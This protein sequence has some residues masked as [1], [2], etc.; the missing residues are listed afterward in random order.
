MARYSLLSLIGVFFII[1]ILLI[2]C[3]G[4]PDVVP[5][6]S[7][8]KHYSPNE[9]PLE[10][11]QITIPFPYTDKFSNG[12]ERWFLDRD[13]SN[14]LVLRITWKNQDFAFFPISKIGVNPVTGEIALGNKKYSVLSLTL[15]SD[16]LPTGSGW[17]T[18]QE[19]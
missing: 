8:A 18:L 14:H 12:E 19:Q 2:G 10:V 1:G 11:N 7:S 13:T 5:L 4:T 17:V 9:T 16:E 3:I 15:N 6:P